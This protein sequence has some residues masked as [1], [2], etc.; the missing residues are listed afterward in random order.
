MAAHRCTKVNYRVVTAAVWLRCCNL[1]FFMCKSIAATFARGHLSLLLG[2]PPLMLRSSSVIAEA[3]AAW[4]LHTEYVG[5]LKKT[6][7][8]PGRKGTERRRKDDK[9]RASDELDK[10]AKC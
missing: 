2:V 6:T 10:I 4:S 3:L 9:L 8:P 1:V 7:Q 5:E